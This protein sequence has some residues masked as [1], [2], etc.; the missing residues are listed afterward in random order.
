MAYTI[1]ISKTESHL[2][3]NL[4][5]YLKS[6]SETKEYDFMQIVEDDEAVLSKEVK[7][8][9][10]DRYEH[11]LKHHQEYTDWEEV[12]KATILWKE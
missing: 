3:K 7:Q 11:F 1:K 4:L 2:A 8:E 5:W 6:L 10:D 12:K 9:L